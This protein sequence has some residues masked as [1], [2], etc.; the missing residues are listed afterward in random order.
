MT[1]LAMVADLL[2]AALAL[3]GLAGLGWWLL[4]LYYKERG[5]DWSRRDRW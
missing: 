2:L 5:Q 3:A 1:A 4:P